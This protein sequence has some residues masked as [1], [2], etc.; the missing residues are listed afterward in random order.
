MSR[1]YSPYN[2][3][4]ADNHTE[5]NNWGWDLP[6]TPPIESDEELDALAAMER[7]WRQSLP[8]QDT[9]QQLIVLYPGA[10]T[11]LL[12]SL[13]AK[14]AIQ[15]DHLSSLSE[16]RDVWSL[17]INKMSP[18]SQPTMIDWL[19]ARIASLMDEYEK[20]IRKLKF[21]IQ[22]V[23]NYGKEVPEAAPKNGV[24]DEQIHRAKQTPISSLIKI[25][26]QRKAQCIWHDDSNPSMHIYGTRV[27]CYPCQK[28]GDAIDVYMTI[29]NVDFQTAVKALAV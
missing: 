18:K 19:D 20:N 17:S 5:Q 10:K 22:Y 29:A 11:A 13:R 27:Y 16:Y 24:T 12:R 23:Q 25:S 14:I 1:W 15:K 21:E 4:T 26:R 8:E 2:A 9:V 6:F 3:M 28:A 7:A